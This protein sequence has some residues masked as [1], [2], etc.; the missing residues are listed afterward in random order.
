[1]MILGMVYGGLPH[2]IMSKLQS[3]INDARLFCWR[4]DGEYVHNSPRD[5]VA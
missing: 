2:H 4:F 5:L 1:M 3:M